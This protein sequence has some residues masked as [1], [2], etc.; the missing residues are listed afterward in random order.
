MAQNKPYINKKPVYTPELYRYDMPHGIKFDYQPIQPSVAPHSHS[1]IEIFYILEGKIQHNFNGISSVLSSGDFAL[2][3]K[4]SVHH[5]SKLEDENCSIINILFYPSFVD[6][7]LS[8][9]D[10]FKDI[11]GCREMQHDNSIMPSD[12]EISQV[13]HEENNTIKTSF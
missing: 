11:L 10:S 2:I 8:S 3:D 4:N 12:F 1:F 6:I 13:Y 5:F 7:S 9:S